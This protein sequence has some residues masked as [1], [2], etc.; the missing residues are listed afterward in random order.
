MFDDSDII[1]TRGDYSVKKFKTFRYCRQCKSIVN[2]VNN[3]NT[4]FSPHGPLNVNVCDPNGDRC[5][6]CNEFICDSIKEKKYNIWINHY[7]L[8]TLEEYVTTKMVKLYPDQ[9][10]NTAK[11]S[12][13]IE[14]FF[15]FN[16][17]TDEKIK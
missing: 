3:K 17:M 16:K 6:S 10:E 9:L 12:L 8:K 5:Q 4:F 14:R 7:M 15:M 2:T 13:T 11:M 1:E